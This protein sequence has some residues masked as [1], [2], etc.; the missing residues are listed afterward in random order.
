MMKYKA[1]KRNA[2]ISLHSEIPVADIK[3]SDNQLHTSDDN[4]FFNI[5]ILNDNK[6]KLCLLMLDDALTE[7]TS[8]D[9]I[10]NKIEITTDIRAGNIIIWTG[11]TDSIRQRDPGA[12]PSAEKAYPEVLTDKIVQEVKNADESY[13]EVILK[14]GKKIITDNKDN[15]DSADREVIILSAWENNDKLFSLLINNSF[16]LS[17]FGSKEEALKAIK[18]KEVHIEDFVKSSSAIEGRIRSVSEKTSIL[19]ND[20]S[21]QEITLQGMAINNFALITVPAKLNIGYEN[22]IKAL[23]P[24][25]NTMIL[26]PAG[27]TME[28]KEGE[29]I[30]KLIKEKI[31]ENLLSQSVKVMERKASDNKYLHKD[32][33]ISMNLLMKYIYDNFGEEA[34]IAYLKQYSRA[35]FKPLNQKLKTGD[36]EALTDYF[37]DI[38]EKEEWPVK[39]TTN[40]NSVE[41]IQDACPGISHIMSKG[42]RPC[43]FYRET[44]STVYKTLCEETPFEYILEYFNE[45]TGA[46]KQLFVLKEV[47]L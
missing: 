23:S 37:R 10:R 12:G 46:C 1:A 22:K 34:L 20:F 33:H 26:Y 32:F 43:P 25:K 27:G 24:Y 42:W 2:V 17:V 35:Y 5:L 29:I 19:Q 7:F 30:T 4:L 8:P 14:I 36:K 9:S 6:T 13:E 47:K 45:E 28:S 16:Q 15:K 38:Y 3:K 21:E 31:L 41:I 44:Y 39:I 11:G 18:D 40:E